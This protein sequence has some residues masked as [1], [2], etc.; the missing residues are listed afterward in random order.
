MS[1]K[2]E[3]QKRRRSPAAQA[4][5]DQKPRVAALERTA[6]MLRAMKEL[7]GSAAATKVTDNVVPL[8]RKPRIGD[9]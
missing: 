1:E 5:A 7:S 8:R 6:G 2:S 4:R 9:I 3:I